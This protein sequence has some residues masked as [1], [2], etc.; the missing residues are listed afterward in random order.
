[1]G[2]RGTLVAGPVQGVLEVVLR[3]GVEAAGDVDDLD[4]AGR[5]GL[6][7]FEVVCGRVSQWCGVV[8]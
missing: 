8:F 1:M 4:V 5:L 7:A 2:P 6:Q 3:D